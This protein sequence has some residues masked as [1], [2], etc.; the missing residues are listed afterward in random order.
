MTTVAITKCA[1][2]CMALHTSGSFRMVRYQSSPIDLTGAF[3][4]LAR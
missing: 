3:G 2:T 4:R 1:V